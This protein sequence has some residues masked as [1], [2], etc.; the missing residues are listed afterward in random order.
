LFRRCLEQAITADQAAR[1]M[2]GLLPAAPCNGYWHGRP[3]LEQIVASS[4]PVA[5]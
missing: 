4:P 3:G 5:A 2:A 1:Q